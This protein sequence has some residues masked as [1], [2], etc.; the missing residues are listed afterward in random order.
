M[1]KA[2][3]KNDLK[4]I[5]PAL[6]TPTDAEGNFKPSETKML[7]DHLICAGVSGIVPMGGTGEFTNMP[8][9]ERVKFVE[10]VV[11]V[12]D[13]RVPVIAGVLSPGFHES[14]EIGTN[15]KNAGAD[16]LM[17]LT[18]FYVKPTQEGLIKYFLSFMDKVKLPVVLYDIP[19][20]TMTFTDPSTIRTIAEKNELL[21]GMKA[22][23]PDLAHFVR[24]MMQAG[25][26]ISILSGEEY[27]YIAHVIL[28]A[29]GGI[30]ATCNLFPDE[31]IKMHT[32]L[33]NK[34]TESAKKILFSLV[35]LLDA[36]F[37]EIN[38]GPLKAAMAN[39]GFN[40]GPVLSPLVAPQSS[41]VEKLRAAT[42]GLKRAS[43]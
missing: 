13:G 35:P 24:L 28:G 38:P 33:L 12:V 32:C 14:V 2:L 26:L 8:P 20:R 6:L 16:A 9:K 21:I 25:D 40:V 43:K 39:A 1:K 5:M 15:F 11:N 23:N 10:F 18:P 36:A 4:G 17:L 34:D 29:R 41:T 42:E 27:L 19:Y 31:W 30:L 3:S 22:C 7:V 37:S